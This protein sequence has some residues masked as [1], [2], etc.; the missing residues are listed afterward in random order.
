M[1]KKILLLFVLSCLSAFA[2]FQYE[3]ATTQYD[4]SHYEGYS[5]NYFQVNVTSGSGT[6]YIVDKINNLYSM[7]GNVEVLDRVMSDYGYIDLSTGDLIAGTG[8][9]IT[10]NQYQA[11]QYNDLVYQT[12]YEVGTFS[13]GESFGLWIANKNGLI[14]TSTYTPHSDFGRY[15]LNR[16]DMF[17]TDLAHFD[18]R[19]SAP[20]SFGI[21]GA[22]A[23]GGAE[24]SGQPL[25]GAFASLLLA[26]GVMGYCQRKR[27][28]E[29]NN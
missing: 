23:S 9:T 5:G 8:N 29:Q 1:I 22:A 15:G 7:P 24:V 20:I 11:N 21:T 2:A 28:K 6:F 25:P 27:K 18:Y 10:T 16:Q 19:G 12:G 26:T 13:A 4:N 14:N 17:G 3:V